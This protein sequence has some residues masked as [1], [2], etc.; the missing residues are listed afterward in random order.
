MP[1]AAAIWRGVKE[2]QFVVFH[3]FGEPALQI[4]FGASVAI[5]LVSLFSQA[6]YA[7]AQ[8]QIPGVGQLTVPGYQQPPPPRYQGPPPDY[9]CQTARNRDPGSACKRDPF[10][11]LVQACPGSE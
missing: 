9:G 8:I 11:A 10:L 5:L 2:R 3:Q 1:T 7:Q 4:I 6:A